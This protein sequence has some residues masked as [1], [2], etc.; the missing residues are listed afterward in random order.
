MHA[1]RV[2]P[3]EEWLAVAVGLL[4]ELQ[5]RVEELLVHR[6]H[7][8]GRQGAGV[9]DLLRSVRIGPAV[10]HTARPE[11]LLEL[12]IFRV[13][14]ALRL[15]LRVQVVEVAEELV[16]AVD[17]GQELVA[18]T[19]VVLAELAGDVTQGLEKVGDRRI[20][21]LQTE[22]GAGQAYLGEAGADG[23]LA[24]DERGPARGATL[25][26]VPVGEH[27]T[28]LSE[29]IDVGSTVS[30]DAVVV[31]ADIEPADV[32]APDDENVRFVGLG[33]FQ[34][35]PLLGIASRTGRALRLG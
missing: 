19:Q 32:V 9:L 16:E 8:L 20:L 3:D 7:A 14:R 15:L 13:V 6:L 26:S 31:G 10:Q 30:H 29:A 27:R 2:P 4:H 23:R 18:V 21:G 34:I 28:F 17:R 35:A 12:G 22:V 33:H 1:G 11:L 5:A 25:L 24:G